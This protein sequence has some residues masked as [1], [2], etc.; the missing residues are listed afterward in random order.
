[1]AIFA[2]PTIKV[3]R[4]GRANREMCKASVP[5]S[6]FTKG[7][8]GRRSWV[9]PSG[10][11]HASAGHRAI[12]D[13]AEAL[14]LPVWHGTGCQSSRAFPALACLQ[15]LPFALAT[16]QCPV[17]AGIFCCLEGKKKVKIMC[18]PWPSQRQ[19]HLSGKGICEG[20]MQGF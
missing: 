14:F 5:L 7:K 17:L 2:L 13:S 4:R 20:E 16:A 9:E 12:S 1:M 8:V 15:S 18:L 3:L 10:A 19:I 6:L 11:W